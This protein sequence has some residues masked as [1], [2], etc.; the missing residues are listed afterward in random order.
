M[1][2]FILAKRGKDHTIIKI[3]ITSFTFGIHWLQINLINLPEM[4][5]N[6]NSP[7]GSM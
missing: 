3:S 7:W 1:A 6:Y 2:I 5:K 4:F